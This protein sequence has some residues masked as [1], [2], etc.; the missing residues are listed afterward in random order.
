MLLL[1]FR[2]HFAEQ[3]PARTIEPHHSQLTYRGIVVRAIV[4][5]DPRQQH[6]QFQVGNG[7][8]L[9]HHIFAAEVIA[10]LLQ[11]MN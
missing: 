8:R 10:A 11:N 6:I 7:R 2:E 9:L 3:L 1:L 4:K 5:S